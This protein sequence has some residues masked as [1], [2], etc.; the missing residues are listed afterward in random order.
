M[1]I[2]QRPRFPQDPECQCQQLDLNI[3]KNLDLTEK[4]VDEIIDDATNHNLSAL[5]SFRCIKELNA[6]VNIKKSLYRNKKNFYA[7][8]SNSNY[9]KLK[10]GDSVMKVKQIN[11]NRKGRHLDKYTDQN[12]YIVKDILV[13]GNIRIQNT[14]TQQITSTPP[15]HLKKHRHPKDTSPYQDSEENKQSDLS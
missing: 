11:K 3:T 7:K 12:L 10:P 6:D 4:E 5:L 14:Q 8:F 2:G 13:N 15:S 1:L 9:V